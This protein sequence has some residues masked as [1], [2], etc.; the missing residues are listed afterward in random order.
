MARAVVC[1]E[2]RRG[3]GI[4]G[5]IRWASRAVTMWERHA[6]GTGASGAIH[7]TPCVCGGVTVITVVRARRGDGHQRRHP[8]GP[9]RL[10]YYKLN[11]YAPRHLWALSVLPGPFFVRRPLL[12]ERA[13]CIAICGAVAPYPLL[14]PFWLH[15][16]PPCVLVL[17]S[18]YPPSLFVRAR[19]RAMCEAS[20]YPLLSPPLVHPPLVPLCSSSPLLP[21]RLSY[22][23]GLRVVPRW[24]LCM[25]V[26]KTPCTTLTSAS[27]L[28]PHLRATTASPA[29]S[30]APAGAPAAGGHL[31]WGS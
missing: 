14:S 6:E 22:P 15:S 25:T 7:W 8:V 4:S 18:L 11:R 16:G 30:T 9:L 13:W 5:A 24:T 28:P 29:A 26:C 17:W 21:P 27:L 2:G 10:R 1:R 12:L 23:R 31:P 19:C 3:T 20:L